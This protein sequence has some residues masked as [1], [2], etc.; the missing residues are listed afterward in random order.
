MKKYLLGSAL[1]LSVCYL[2]ATRDRTGMVTPLPASAAVPSVVSAPITKP[3]IHASTPKGAVQTDSSED[4][5][6]VADSRGWPSDL[7]SLIRVYQSNRAAIADVASRQGRYWVQSPDV[8][9]GLMQSLG[10]TLAASVTGSDPKVMDQYKIFKSMYSAI[11]YDAALQLVTAYIAGHSAE[12]STVDFALAEKFASPV[13]DKLRSLAAYSSMTQDQWDAV[14]AETKGGSTLSDAVSKHLGTTHARAL[15]LMPVL[16]EYAWQAAMAQVSDADVS[17]F[18][19]RALE[20]DSQIQ[21]I[22]KNDPE[23]TI[24]ADELQRA[25]QAELH[26]WA[27]S[28]L[29]R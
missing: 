24:K 11:P 12:G 29:K 22:S 19:A 25:K 27:A 21:A 16:G 26:S 9:D 14:W 20:Y 17:K 7:V 3:S 2:V 10:R 23:R 15:E 28:S 1:I 8:Y 4:F 18:R 5:A 13:A 6:S